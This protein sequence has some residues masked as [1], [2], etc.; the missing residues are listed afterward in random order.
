MRLSDILRYDAGALACG[1]VFVF[2]LAVFFFTSRLLLPTN[3][4]GILALGGALGT[5]VWSTASRALWA[6]TWGMLLLGIVVYLLLAHEVGR[7][8]INPIVLATLLSWMYFVRPTYAVPIL[9]I[10][11]YLF[12]F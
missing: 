12:I 6:D 4:S 8:R 3:W 11:A 1:L 5:Q 7:R 10:T 2:T 9:A